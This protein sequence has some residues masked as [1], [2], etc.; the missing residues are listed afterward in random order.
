LVVDN[1]DFKPKKKVL[2]ISE[3]LNPDVFLAP[4]MISGF[5]DEK[6]APD[7]ILN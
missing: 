6:Q 1:Q 3:N 5:L 4:R 2:K 7:F